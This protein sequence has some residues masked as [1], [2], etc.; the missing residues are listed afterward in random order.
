MD[1]HYLQKLMSILIC[2]GIL[3]LVDIIILKNLLYYFL[4]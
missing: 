1:I 2:F 4:F 3:V